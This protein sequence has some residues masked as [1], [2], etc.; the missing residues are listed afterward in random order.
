[1]DIVN[2]GYIGG[3]LI[4]C[5]CIPQLLKSLNNKHTKDASIPNFN[6]IDYIDIPKTSKATFTVPSSSVY[7]AY[8]MY[9][10][11]NTNFTGAY[12][13]FSLCSSQK[14][15]SISRL[16]GSEGSDGQRLHATWGDAG[17]IKIFQQ[18]AGSGEGNYT[19]KVRLITLL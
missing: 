17:K 13:V 12:A 14:G 9:V 10:G 18:A 8:T 6:L 19:Y 15:W 5:I 1:M 3:A 11:D 4:A 2:I 16:S 7:G